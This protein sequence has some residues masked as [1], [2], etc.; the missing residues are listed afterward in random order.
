MDEKLHAYLRELLEWT[1]AVETSFETAD[2]TIGETE[3]WENWK[4]EIKDMMYKENPSHEEVQQLEQK[5]EIFHTRL[6]QN[7]SNESVAVGQHQLPPLPYAYNALEPYI[8]EQIMRLH[9]DSHHQSYVN[10]LNKAEVNLYQSKPNT[11]LWKHWFR[12]Q[13][14]H[15]S[16]HYLHTIF[17]FNMKPNGGGE[18]PKKTDIAKQITNDFGSFSAFKEIFRKGAESVEGVGWTM[19]VWSPRAGRLAIQTLEKHQDFSLGDTIPLLVLDVWEHA[20]YLQYNNDRKEY[21]KQWWNVINWED[22]N[23]RFQTA[24]QVKWSLF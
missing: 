20:Y 9:H 21:I 24:K 22:V 8:S 5:G 11:P 12:E 18:P 10:G 17:W 4:E 7:T 1:N 16:G 19:L 14:F 3:D 6:E 13:A 15:G 23:N 2:R